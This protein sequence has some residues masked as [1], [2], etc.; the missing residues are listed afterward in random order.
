MSDFTLRKHSV[1]IAGHA[2]S[3]TLEDIF[4]QQLERMAEEQGISISQLLAK[5][6]NGRMAESA[7][8]N[9]SSAIRVTIVQYLLDTDIYFETADLGKCGLG[10]DYV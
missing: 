1:T 8:I 4:W 9:L 2:T 10:G 7:G 6:D 3:I 5:I